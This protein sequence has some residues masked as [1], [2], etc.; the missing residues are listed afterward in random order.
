MIEKAKKI[1]VVIVPQFNISP[2]DHVCACVCVCVCVLCVCACNIVSITLSIFCVGK[3]RQ[4]LGRERVA[5]AYTNNSWG[6]RIYRG[7]QRVDVG[8]R[9]GRTHRQR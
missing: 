2:N 1:K 6:K 9:D 3:F 8:Y 4:P 7:S 5:R